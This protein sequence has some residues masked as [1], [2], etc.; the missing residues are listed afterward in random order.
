VR[1]IGCA[2]VPDEDSFDI[3]AA[4]LRADGS[5]LSVAVEVLASKLEDA[6]A[7]ETRVVRRSKRLLSKDKRVERIDV[8]LGD[9]RFGLRAQDSSVEC[10][11]ERRSGGIAIKR[12]ALSLDEWV[13]AL[14][15]ELRGRAQQSARAREALTRLMN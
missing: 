8:N 12:E 5:E 14:T 10:Y 1:A 9:W 6:L 2:A 13:A 7:A 4:G 15:G 11:R 3:A